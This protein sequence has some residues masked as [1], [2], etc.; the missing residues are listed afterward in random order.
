M[1]VDGLKN[2]WLVRGKPKVIIVHCFIIVSDLDWLECWSTFKFGFRGDSLVENA[3]ERYVVTAEALS[4]AHLIVFCWHWHIYGSIDF[5]LR[6][7]FGLPTSFA[8]FLFL[9]APPP[10]QSISRAK[11]FD[12]S[13]TRKNFENGTSPCWP[14]NSNCCCCCCKSN[15][16]CCSNNCWPKEFC[17]WKEFCCCCWIAVSWGLGVGPTCWLSILGSELRLQST[18]AS[19]SH[20]LVNTLYLQSIISNTPNI[21]FASRLCCINPLTFNVQPDQ[22]GLLEASSTGLSSSNSV[23]AL[24]I[25]VAFLH[26]RKVTLRRWTI[27]VCVTLTTHL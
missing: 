13:Q 19:Q 17:G 7:M 4:N 25:H 11:D 24:V 21:W 20:W 8:S 9:T 18:E 5:E 12:S 27:I 16:C 15:C 1:V 10:P 14:S 26:I 22:I 3:S 2:Y 23:C 6:M